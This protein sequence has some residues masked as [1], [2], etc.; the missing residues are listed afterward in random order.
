MMPVMNNQ[1]APIAQ[2]MQ[3]INMLTQANAQARQIEQTIRSRSPQQLEQMVRN[4][5][6]ERNTTPEDLARSLGIQIPSNR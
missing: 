2:L 4:M 5:C 1:P 6:K 3:R